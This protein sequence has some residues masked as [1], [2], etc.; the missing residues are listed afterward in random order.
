MWPEAIINTE[1]NYGGIIMVKQQNKQFIF[2]PANTYLVD[3]RKYQDRE[4]A[5]FRWVIKQLEN[6]RKAGVA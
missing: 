1:A 5:R 2:I 6:R 3:E 4:M